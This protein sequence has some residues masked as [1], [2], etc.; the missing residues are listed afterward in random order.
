MQK[1]FDES[2]ERA[3]AD[4]DNANTT[5]G[6][7]T[8]LPSMLSARSYMTAFYKRLSSSEARLN[9]DQLYAECEATHPAAIFPGCGALFDLYFVMFGPANMHR[10]ML[11]SRKY[12]S[13]HEQN[14]ARARIAAKLGGRFY[15][16]LISSCRSISQRACTRQLFYLS[17]PADFRG[18]SGELGA[19]LGWL[20]W[21]IEWLILGSLVCHLVCICHNSVL[22]SVVYCVRSDVSIIMRSVCARILITV[23]SR[24]LTLQSLVANSLLHLT[25]L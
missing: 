7:I 14:A 4:N 1:L 19:P 5:F 23:L 9:V 2:L 21:R 20:K 3:Q 8:L 18:L 17:L 25:P 10:S 15:Y 22:G 16:W 11:A 24:V 6:H 13:A 12:G